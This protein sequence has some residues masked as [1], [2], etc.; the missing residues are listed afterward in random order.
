MRIKEIIEEIDQDSNRLTE[1][2][3]RIEELKQQIRKVEGTI[4]E[5]GGQDYRNKKDELERIAQK[6]SELEKMITRMKANLNNTDTNIIRH[7]KEV[8]KE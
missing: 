8:E 4:L 3:P 6:C 1:I 7:D 2:N 5:A